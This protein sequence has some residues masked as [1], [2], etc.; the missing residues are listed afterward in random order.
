[1]IWLN[2]KHSEKFRVVYFIQTMQVKLL[3]NSEERFLILKLIK[4]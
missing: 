2:E 4:S 1:M 3:L